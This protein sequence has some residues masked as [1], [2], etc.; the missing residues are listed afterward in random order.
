MFGWS[1]TMGGQKPLLQRNTHP[2][3][4]G[5]VSPPAAP[6]PTPTAGGNR[7]AFLVQPDRFPKTARP[8][9]AARN[10]RQS[11]HCPRRRCGTVSREASPVMGS[12]VGDWSAGAPRSQPPG[13]FGSFHHW[14]E[15]RRGNSAAPAAGSFARGGKGTKTPFFAAPLAVCPFRRAKFEWLF[16]LF[17]GHWALAR[18]R[19]GPAASTG[20]AW[21]LPCCLAGQETAGG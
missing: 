10:G 13:I 4:R 15:H 18:R 14:K 16:P 11:Y 5:G 17:P 3:R 9:A 20:S 8:A 12:G 2:L 19:F 6:R 7:R 21:P 1:W